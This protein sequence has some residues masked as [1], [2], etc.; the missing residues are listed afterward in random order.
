MT[1]LVPSTSAIGNA[2][3][4]EY[5]LPFEV[6][7]VVLLAVLVGAIVLSRKEVREEEAAGSR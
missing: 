6:A 4:S 2:L 5:V 3:L 1:E 7:S